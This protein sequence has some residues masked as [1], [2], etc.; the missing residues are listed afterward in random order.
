MLTVIQ[1]LSL[2][3]IRVCSIETQSILYRTYM[4]FML[5]LSTVCPGSSDPPEKVFD[6]FASENEVL[7]HLLTITIL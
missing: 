3:K 4:E 1:M 7:H 2:V 6:I 5:K